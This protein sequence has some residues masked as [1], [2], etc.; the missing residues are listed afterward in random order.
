MLNPSIDALLTKIDSKYTLVT[1]AAKRARE[2]QEHYDCR[3]EHPVSH[4]Y[5]GKALEE[6]DSRFLDYRPTEEKGNK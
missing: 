6:I 2:L 5:V 3:I 4:K 1:V